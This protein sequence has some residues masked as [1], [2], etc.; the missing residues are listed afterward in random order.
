MFLDL[1]KNHMSLLGYSDQQIGTKL[2]KI[3]V[4][5]YLYQNQ[6]PKNLEEGG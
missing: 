1:Q 5:N 6:N 4:K 2:K 3:V